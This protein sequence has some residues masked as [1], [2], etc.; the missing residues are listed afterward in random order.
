MTAHQCIVSSRNLPIRKL[1][2]TTLANAWNKLL[3]SD[4]SITA[5]GDPNTEFRSQLAGLIRESSG[6]QECDQEN[7]ENWLECDVDDPGHQVLTYDE[8]I[9]SVIDDQDLCN[10]EEDPS[11][12]DCAE[13]GPSS[14][15]AFH[16]L[17]TAMK[18]VEQQEE[19]D[20]SI[21]NF[22]VQ[23]SHSERGIHKDK[24]SDDVLMAMTYVPLNLEACNSGEVK[25]MAEF[26]SKSDSLIEDRKCRQDS[27]SH[28]NSQNHLEIK[29]DDYSVI[30]FLICHGCMIANSFS[31]HPVHTEIF[32]VTAA[33][34]SRN[35]T[36]GADKQWTQDNK[37]TQEMAIAPLQC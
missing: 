11:D 3:P 26:A 19:C 34:E 6:F 25:F 24:C 27:T 31:H 32:R 15:E 33:I 37:K 36:Y 21:G 29:E 7:I 22:E 20:A 17:E 23:T 30:L 35:W 2:D 12:E 4:E 14:E 10:E 13:K 16:C 8:I 1:K 9:A 5:P 28:S 18:W